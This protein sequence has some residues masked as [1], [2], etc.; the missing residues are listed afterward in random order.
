MPAGDYTLSDN[1]SGQSVSFTISAGQ[2]TY[3]SVARFYASN[4][5]ASSMTT[6][7]AAGGQ[8][9]T[10]PT[11]GSG[12]GSPGQ[13]NVAIVLILLGSSGLTCLAALARAHR[14]R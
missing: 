2:A 10:L 3:V 8:A 14:E 6:A 13:S 5:A 11:T 1:D 4:P 12:P 9:T 7:V